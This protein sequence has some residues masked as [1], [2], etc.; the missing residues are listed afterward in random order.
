MREPRDIFH[1]V[2]LGLLAQI[3]YHSPKFGARSL[4]RIQN[5]YTGD[6]EILVWGLL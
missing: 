1:I 2:N 3:L 6:F 5:G 4:K